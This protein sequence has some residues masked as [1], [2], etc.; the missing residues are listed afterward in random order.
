MRLFW[1]SLTGQIAILCVVLALF[2]GLWMLPVLLAGFPYQ[3]PGLILARN[4]AETG[5]FSLTDSLGRMLSPSLLAS[6]GVISTVDG[7]LS[8]LL[9]VLASHWLGWDQFLGWTL[10]SSAVMGVS[11]LL[12]WLAVYR[13]LNARSAWLSTILLGLTPLIWQQALTVDNYSFAF[14]FLFASFAAFVWLKDRS[15]FGAVALAGILFGCSSASKDVFLVFLPWY[16][17]AYLWIHR[18]AWKRGIL[19]VVLFFILAGSIYLA[20]YIGDIRALGYPV[21]QNI[22]RVWPGD[23]QLEDATYLHLYPDPYTYYFDREAFDAEHLA[24]VEQWSWLARMQEQKTLLNYGLTSGPFTSLA[25]SM[26]LFLHSFPSLFQQAMVGSVVLWLFIVPGFLILLHREKTLAV[27]LVGLVLSMYAMIAFVLHYEREHLMD[28]VWVLTLFAA[29]GVGGVSDTLASSWKRV[30]S[31]LLTILIMIVLGVQLVQT[32][33][34]EFARLYRAS[35]VPTALAQAQLLSSLPEDAVVALPDHSTRVM[36]LAF[37]SGRTMVSFKEETV[38]R[39]RAERGLK[40]AFNIY[41][42]THALG[43]SQDLGQSIHSLV[44]TV[45][46]LDVV[47]RGERNMVTPFVNYLLHI[48]R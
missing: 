41:A 11:L 35:T 23:Q 6:E 5:M 22:S 21:N 28:V 42:V 48:I 4:V 18:R 9:Y 3:F 1:K 27:L 14:F 44:P 31:S 40:N 12:L 36:D 19:G 38:E 7:R 46:V 2:V 34:N 29:L 43:Y 13:L 33:R 30:S 26:W 32:N 45:T 17:V 24:E 10:L 47:E 39:L 15:H 37:L 20:P 8:A 25:N 16:V